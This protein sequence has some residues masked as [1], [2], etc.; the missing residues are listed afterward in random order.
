MYEL[1]VHLTIKQKEVLDDCFLEKQTIQQYL[2]E[3]V[4]I[5]SGIDATNSITSQKIIWNKTVDGKLEQADKS[6]EGVNLSDH[7]LPRDPAWVPKEGAC[8][9]AAKIT[10]KIGD[11]LLDRLETF[12]QI[13]SLRHDLFIESQKEYFESEYNKIVEIETDKK[14]L[15]EVKDAQTKILEKNQD[16]KPVSLEQIL[17]AIC[18][19]SFQQKMQT[20]EKEILIKENQEIANEEKP[21]ADKKVELK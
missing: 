16:E 11:K 8:D 18:M 19:Q 14:V 5:H 3:D 10:V 4:L 9:P 20:H 13:V 1:N 2:R 17:N 6:L 15:K 7:I 12:A 21:P